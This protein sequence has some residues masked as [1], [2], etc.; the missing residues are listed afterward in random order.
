MPDTS[1]SKS[2][3]RQRRVVIGFALLLLAV[4]SAVKWL[5]R[6]ER[7][8][9]KSCLTRNQWKEARARLSRLLW[10]HPSDASVRMMLAEAYARDD[11]LPSRSS[12]ERAVAL[13][14]DIPDDVAESAEARI[15]E[16][17]LRFL[18][19]RQPIQAERILQ[20]AMVIDPKAMDAHSLHWRI[21]DMTGRSDLCEPIFQQLYELSPPQ[22]RIDYLRDWF[23]SQNDPE[24]ITARLDEMLGFRNSPDESARRLEL[25]RL[26]AFRQSE[27]NEPLI[28]A[29]IARWFQ[30]E[31]DLEQ[32]LHVVNEVRSIPQVMNDPLFVFALVSVL[33]E[34][35]R[36]E[37]AAAAF[38]Q[39][40]GLSEGYAYW[41]T[42]GLLQE[43]LHRNYGAA[44]VAYAKSLAIWPG[45]A[46][47]R[48]QFRQ[49]TCLA[50]SGQK[51]LADVTRQHAIEVQ[52]MFR[53]DHRKRLQQAL[54]APHETP[55]RDVILEFYRTLRRPDEAKYWQQ[56]T[57]Q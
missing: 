28:H 47:W 3:H 41:K 50:L 14:K 37:Q 26:I 29:A 42:A 16:A 34:S 21:L 8:A 18:L 40:P 52:Q 38:D 56:I 24:H 49:A 9:A 22:Q 31:G 53:P 19:L 5:D 25:K 54:L 43:N 45:H 27:P 7:L 15:R 46:D 6:S 2:K 39:W 55:N 44:S 1:I 4:I 17:R 36:L 35:G 51:E 32:A 23:F 20:R 12:A 30:D 13:L 48:C 10:W 11:S 57:E 33:I